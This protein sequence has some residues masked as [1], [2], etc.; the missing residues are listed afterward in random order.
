MIIIE[1]YIQRYVAQD[2]EILCAV[3]SLLIFTATAVFE[4]ASK[5]ILATLLMSVD[6]TH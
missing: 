5:V 3:H 4:L 2:K 6:H 1:E